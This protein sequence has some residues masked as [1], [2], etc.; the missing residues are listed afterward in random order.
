[1]S[2]TASMVKELRETTG[3]G[4]M[5]CKGAL[6]ET[7][8]NIDEAVEILR[9]KGV[10][11][12]AKKAS[13]TAKDGLIGNY[14]SDDGKMGVLV[15]I[16]CE[17]DFVTKTEDFQ[18]F[19]EKITGVVCEKNP[20]DMD[21]LMDIEYEGDNVKNFQTAIVAK[22]GENIGIRRFARK[23]VEGDKKLT[24]YIHAGSKI[25]VMVEFVDPAGKLD[26]ATARDVAMHV[27]AMNPQFVCRDEVPESVLSKEKEIML[28]QMA[29]TKKPAEIMEKI[30]TGKM[31]KFYSEVC[32]EEQTFV[33]DP[34]GKS[35]VGN[36]LKKIDDGIKLDSF[37]RLQ[38]GEGV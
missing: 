33:K 26:D 30:V 17:T 28:A 22:I 16:N 8:G 14:L 9:K 12:A 13:R 23:D 31:G 32:L 35:S 1:M 36:W 6:A 20:A 11:K 5:D 15:E 7:N 2:I 10:A 27:A 25:G 4:M 21:A 38:V 19:V 34:D 18:G 29:D 24:N 3:A 37:V